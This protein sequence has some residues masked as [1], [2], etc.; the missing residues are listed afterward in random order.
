MKR[1]GVDKY[2]VAGI[3]YGGFVAYRVAE[4][5]GEGAVERVVVMTAGIVAGEEER[6]ELVEREGRDVSDVLLPRRPEDLME[7]IRRSMVRPPRWMPEF[8]L[9]DFIE[10]M[11]K[12]RR[13]ERVELLKYLIA[14]G[15]GV[16]PLPVLKQ[17]TLILW[18]DQDTVFPISL[19]YKLQRHLGPKARLEVIKDAGHALPLEKPDLVN[20]MIEWFLT[21]PYQSV[22]T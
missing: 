20:H 8:L 6:R 1:L 3:S 18:G 7:L 13:K 14:K 11:Y 16:D 12:D 17:E 9:M 10:V 19:A 22:S 2:C 4:M 15:A 5:A 21:E